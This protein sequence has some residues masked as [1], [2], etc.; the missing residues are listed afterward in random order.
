VSKICRPRLIL[1]L[2][3][4]LLAPGRFLAADDFE[5]PNSYIGNADWDGGLVLWVEVAGITLDDGISLPL[6]LRFTSKG[7]GFLFGKNWWCPLLESTA[8]LPKSHFIEYSTLG[9]GGE[10]LARGNQFVSDDGRTKATLD[11]DEIEIDSGGWVYRYKDGKITE[12]KTPDGTSLVWKKDG[13]SI[14]LE[15]AGRRCVLAIMRTG[16]EA[17]ITISSQK[18]EF[19]LK[20]KSDK[21]G[22]PVGWVLAFPDGRREEMKLER[23]ACGVTQMTVEGS[24]GIRGIYRWKTETGELLADSDFT[25]EM[26][27]TDIGR[28]LLNRVDGQGQTEWY[29]FDSDKGAA[30]YKRQ[31]GSRVVSWY[32]LRRGPA[33]MKVFRMDTLSGDQKLVSSRLLSY[34]PEG[35]L[36]KEWT[37]E[38]ERGNNSSKGIRFIAL[39]EAMKLHAETGTLFIDARHPAAFR[40]GA[41]PGS[42]NLSRV[43]FE[44]DYAGKDSLLKGA[45]T[46]V[47]YCT[48]RN[49][50]DSSIVA[51]K[52]HN[53]GHKNVVVFE[54][55]W[56]EW[57]K[58]SRSR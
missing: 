1:P 25:Y 3:L 14:S 36:D 30:T 16:D 31:D 26:R 53:L 41:I 48:S 49:C 38:G 6:R 8:I 46:L 55:G 35:V 44:R 4:L 13:E 19:I 22:D 18:A 43:A 27:P 52:L 56:A 57:W 58:H 37:E 29:Y 10:Y 28:D 23:Q 51:T 21:N 39:D 40:A 33:H 20:Q 9:G 42:V 54:G 11:S 50:E 12:A 17:K 24:G 2:L 15:V 7:K 32:D 45:K 34:T 5:H 47:V